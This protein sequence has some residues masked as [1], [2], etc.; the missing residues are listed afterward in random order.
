MVA[1]IELIVLKAA[2]LF[3]SIADLLFFILTALLGCGLIFAFFWI[4][5]WFGKRY[6]M[7]WLHRQIT[8][9]SYKFAISTCFVFM[10]VPIFI[11]CLPFK[12]VGD[13][14][15][16]ESYLHAVLPKVFDG[17]Q[18]GV[19]FDRRLCDLFVAVIGYLIF[20]GF[21]TSMFFNM[22][23]RKMN[24]II[25]GDEFYPNQKDHYVVIGSGKLLVSLINNIFVQHSKETKTTRCR[26]RL[27]IVVIMANASIPEL[28]KSV[29]SQIK[30]EY[31]N[32]VIFVRGS[33]V[34]K[35][36]LSRL[37]LST[38]KAVYLMGDFGV[39]NQDDNNLSA[40][41]IINDVLKIN[42]DNGEK[43]N[44]YVYLER[45][46]T[47][48]LFQ[49]F[50]AKEDLTHLHLVPVC[51]YRCWA[52]ALLGVR[53]IV[54]SESGNIIRYPAVFGG[55]IKPDSDDF[56]HLV[57]IGMSRMGMSLV[58]EAALLLHFPNS[59]R[60][61]TKITMIDV[62]AGQEMR[63]LVNLHSSLFS[64]AHYTYTE[65]SN[66]HL[67]ESIPIVQNSN[68]GW[69][70]TEFHFI[71]AAAESMI[72][73]V[74]L[75]KFAQEKG[76]RLA[77]AICLPDALLHALSLP[78]CLFDR[79]NVNIYVQQAE[80]EGL[81]KH[82]RNEPASPYSNVYPF[83]MHNV[84]VCG[85]SHVD[86]LAIY[87]DLTYFN[88]SLESWE[89]L[90]NRVKREDA[91]R[92]KKLWLNMD[93]WKRISNRYAAASVQIK[94]N[95]MATSDKQIIENLIEKVYADDS[96]RLFGE[97]EHNRWCVEKLITGFRKLTPE[98][99]KQFENGE[100]ESTYKK[101]F[102]HPALRPWKEICDKPQYTSYYYPS[103][104]MGRSIC[105][106]PL[107]KELI[108]KETPQQVKSS[109]NCTKVKN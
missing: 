52:E 75:N 16:L 59:E 4:C 15:I 43:K 79:E 48:S 72:V 30:S 97:M 54:D 36:D 108:D 88:H 69:L 103:I 12:W 66:S 86:D 89:N 96:A 49:S 20:S 13:A 40:L 33:R 81:L 95:S 76:S 70:D 61:R 31:E 64:E 45:Y 58:T 65:Y 42:G 37:G 26:L 39:N 77:V 80:R 94:L 92:L 24:K 62:N 106:L 1:L 71:Q 38:C 21:T 90:V 29:T 47:Y 11:F 6:S 2:A 78:R 9:M 84:D 18:E 93:L 3:E 56:V 101:K 44:C 73:R 87:A 68:E 102:A 109:T 17:S 22:I 23:Q 107:I 46:H 51:F 25:E 57:I 85:E 53:S 27:P 98:E 8:R 10:A 63:K 67:G 14:T 99:Q 105:F 7:I 32:K 5:I 41:S 91:Q 35:E 83:G 28:R 82:L 50:F 60:K 74:L 34:N 104:N 55:G 19:K 100:S